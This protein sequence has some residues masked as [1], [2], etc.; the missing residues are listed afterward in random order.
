M[1]TNGWLK[2]LPVT[3]DGAGIV[4]HAGVAAADAVGQHRPD[5]RSS[6]GAPAVEGTPL[7]GLLL[8]DRD[9]VLTD[10]TSA[11]PSLRSRKEHWAREAPTT[12]PASRAVN[13][14]RTRRTT[15]ITARTDLASPDRRRDESSRL[16]RREGRTAIHLDYRASRVACRVARQVK[17][18]PDNLVSLP[19]AAQRNLGCRPSVERVHV[20]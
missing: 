5:R 6:W 20:P 9:Q 3:A 18:S 14:P 1:N 2:G 4:P 17:G 12:R 11:K 13:I 19:A 15:P 7:A 16:A 8:H 10:L